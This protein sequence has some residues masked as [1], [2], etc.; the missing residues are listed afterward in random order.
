MICQKSCTISAVKVRGV[1]EGKGGK[2]KGRKGGR[3]EKKDRKKKKMLR[4]ET[5]VTLI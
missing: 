2:E 5:K 3:E 1:R 4:Q